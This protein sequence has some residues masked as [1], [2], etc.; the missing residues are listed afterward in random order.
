MPPPTWCPSP[1]PAPPARALC[2]PCYPELHYVLNLMTCLYHI[3]ICS[4]GCTAQGVRLTRSFESYALLAPT[5]NSG[6]YSI[7]V[8]DG[9]FCETSNDYATLTTLWGDFPGSLKDS[10]DSWK[11]C[12]P[13][14]KP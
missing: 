3:Q 7:T 4:P 6:N 14:V 8:Y 12:P 13:G 10:V 1:P 2:V 5:S 11:V 9:N